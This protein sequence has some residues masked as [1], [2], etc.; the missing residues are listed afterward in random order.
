MAPVGLEPN[1]L[2]I[3]NTEHLRDYSATSAAESGAYTAPD[4]ELAALIAVWPLLPAKLKA[5]LMA[6]ID[7]AT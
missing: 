2:T 7:S 1:K 6:I 5:G 3:A 4:P